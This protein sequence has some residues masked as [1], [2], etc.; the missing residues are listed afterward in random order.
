MQNT[1]SK[2]LLNQLKQALPHTTSIQ[3]VDGSVI[4][5]H[6]HQQQRSSPSCVVVVTTLE[7]L[8]LNVE[9][10]PPRGWCIHPNPIPNE[11]DIL[12][13]LTLFDSLHS[14]IGHY[15]RLY[16]QSFQSAVVA[17][18][19]ASSFTTPAEEIEDT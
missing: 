3:N 8:C 1:K 15:S 12:L 16:R 4:L 2:E 14:L 17:K 19:S 6:D 13:T 10:Q 18:L 5:Y 11:N 9:Y 7:N